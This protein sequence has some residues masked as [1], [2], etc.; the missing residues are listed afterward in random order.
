MLDTCL[1]SDSLCSLTLHSVHYVSWEA[2][3]CCYGAWLVLCLAH[4][5]RS[6]VSSVSLLAVYYTAYSSWWKETV[7]RLTLASCTCHCLWLLYHFL[8]FSS[9]V[10]FEER[11]LFGSTL[12]P[13]L[14]F[15]VTETNTFEALFFF[16]LIQRRN[17]VIE[18]RPK[19][20]WWI[21]WCFWNGNVWNFIICSYVLRSCMEHI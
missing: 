3:T 11:Y 14:Y 9:L 2:D 1:G 4:W 16:F 12:M 17:V 7:V 10:L 20:C 5:I 13:Q 15:L 6:I 21:T 18:E 8:T 19:Y